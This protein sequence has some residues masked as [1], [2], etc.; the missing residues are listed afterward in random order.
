VIARWEGEFD[1]KKA[2]QFQSD[3]YE[4]KALETKDKI[5]V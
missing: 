4:V 2:I 1:D 5:H 3:T